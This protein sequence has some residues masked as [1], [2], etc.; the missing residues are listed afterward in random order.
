MDKFYEG[1]LV[2]DGE[3]IFTRDEIIETLKRNSDT[4]SGY[5]VILLHRR[6]IK[7]D[8]I[9]TTLKDV[10]SAVGVIGLKCF[11]YDEDGVVYDG[12]ESVI[13]FVEFVETLS[14]SDRV[15]VEKQF[16]KGYYQEIM[17]SIF[18]KASMSLEIVDMFLEGK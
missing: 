3:R 15:K 6:I 4:I 18:T 8:M 1:T 16:G 14:P 10:L 12:L 11:D 17:K 13:L 2:L 5:S 9:L 7:G